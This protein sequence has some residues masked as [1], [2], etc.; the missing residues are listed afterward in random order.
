M[1]R[2]QQFGGG[3]AHGGYAWF[4]KV[5][6]DFS[7]QKNVEIFNYMSIDNALNKQYSLR[8]NQ[9]SCKQIVININITN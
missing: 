9:Y 4:D 6:N 2:D 1:K 5:M 8:I 7:I 3:Y